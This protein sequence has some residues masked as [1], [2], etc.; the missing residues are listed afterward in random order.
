M[1]F[2]KSK[3]K[4]VGVAT[5][6]RAE[7]TQ[8][9]I[10]KALVTYRKSVLLCICTAFSGCIFG[11][12]VGTIG[13]VSNFKGFK[14]R[15]GTIIDSAG[16]NAFPEIIVGLI[17][18]V[19]NIG[20]AIGGLAFGKLADKVGRRSSIF[21]AIFIYA[22]GIVV[23]LSAQVS[24]KW[25]Q[26]MVGRIITGFAVGGTSVVTPMFI[27]ES[28]PVGIR[29][30]MV[31]LYQLM[32]TFGILLGNIVN[33]A[34][35]KHQT[36]DAQWMIPVGLGLLFAFL[37][38]IGS[39]MMPESATY[40]VT[41]GKPV[42]A[43][44]SIAAL[45]NTTPESDV[46]TTEIE[47]ITRQWNEDQANKM[48]TNWYEFITG[49]PRLGRRLVI[50]MLVMAFQ[51]FTGANYFFY[52]GT[53][54]FRSVGLQNSYI[55]AIILGA[56]NFFSTFAGIDFVERFGRKTCLKFGAMLMAV[57]FLIYTLLG[58]FALSDG[59]GGERTAVGGVMIAVTCA[60]IFGFAS[61]WGP[62]AFVVVSELFPSRVKANSMSA[63]TACNWFSNFLISLF[64]PFITKAIGF[65]YGFVF[66][67]CLCAATLFVWFCLPET[68]GLQIH[69][70]D[71]YY[72]GTQDEEQAA[73]GEEAPT[74]VP[75]I[76][77]DESLEKGPS[78]VQV[79]QVNS[80]ATPS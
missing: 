15:F 1:S 37:V 57:C 44:K 61:T 5:N 50:G 56:V 29:G 47:R 77:S 26:F 78:D 30:A 22:I 53:T 39:A 36:G 63:A 25:Y 68:K 79:S 17:V 28:A 41:K 66:F 59:H 42:Q 19:F 4:K 49:Q 11:W 69:E 21:A 34:C 52:Y 71:A 6:K 14:D 65:K 7:H 2:F 3:G 31:V 70:V 16:D 18:S 20:C 60:Y 48:N 72:R 33:F 45:N 9:Q 75:A 67:G 40:L 8:H 38:V 35:D 10:G 13:G 74:S 54:L 32:I 43:S 73:G 62:V 55:T 64:S 80:S 46:C 27:S 12:D 76:G 58:S 23:Q 51:Q 24:S